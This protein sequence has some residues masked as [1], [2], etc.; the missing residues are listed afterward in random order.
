MSLHRACCCGGE[1][2][3]GCVC[4]PT[5]WSR[6]IDTGDPRIRDIG[7]GQCLI[8]GFTPATTNY[9]RRWRI[10]CTAGGGSSA[11]LT[12]LD[13]P[14][15]HYQEYE[16]SFTGQLVVECARISLEEV[17]SATPTQ[18]AAALFGLPE[19]DCDAVPIYERTREDATSPLVETQVGWYLR[20]A[21]SSAINMTWTET[22]RNVHTGLQSDPGE[23]VVPTQVTQRSFGPGVAAV[24]APL[25]REPNRE[26]CD[27]P[28]IVPPTIESLLTPDSQRFQ[29]GG[30]LESD[31]CS[32]RALGRPSGLCVPPPSGTTNP[33]AQFDACG[34]RF[35]CTTSR[36]DG[37]CRKDT[38][39]ANGRGIRCDGR[40]GAIQQTDS[41]TAIGT[42]ET[43]GA[44]CDVAFN[45][46]SR[47]DVS[48]TLT[49]QYAVDVLHTCNGEQD[50][51]DGFPEPPAQGPPPEGECGCDAPV[52]EADILIAYPCDPDRFAPDNPTLE[53]VGY[54]ATLLLL[55]DSEFVTLQRRITLAD[56]SEATVCY[57]PT[58][59]RTTDLEVVTDFIWGSE[60]CDEDPCVR[61]PL[62][63]GF[64]I[65]RRCS[66]P[67]E[68]AVVDTRNASSGPGIV[69]AVTSISEGQHCYYVTDEPTE[70]PQTPGLTV[71]RSLRGCA[72]SRCNP[73]D[74]QPPLPGDR[75]G[76]IPNE[77][78][79]P[80]PGIPE[81]MIQGAVFKRCR[82][83]GQ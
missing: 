17:G 50:A 31:S 5:D 68:T 65:A 53:P 3:V 27:F 11:R 21:D 51:I 52:D 78:S 25:F 82:G 34:N 61:P 7:S 4:A 74:P 58:L 49:I 6:L 71:F 12:N 56:G 37:S 9:G 44:P 72:S 2:G 66:N 67:N 39:A 62:P 63:P 46:F 54:P 13:V 35:D 76:D 10:R 1:G 55:W 20:G 75:P 19:A 41:L 24:V 77:A 64:R 15:G 36:F 22:G 40:S 47:H 81:H 48:A 57:R 38:Y 16:F 42:N 28:I 32:V 26:G 30:M 29:F 80:I 33:M 73:E 59:E 18:I 14:Q 70:G 60:A 69:M 43:S 83:C 79:A 23:C 8:R 45:P